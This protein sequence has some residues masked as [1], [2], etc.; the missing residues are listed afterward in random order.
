L[1]LAGLGVPATSDFCG[2]RG[3]FG[4]ENGDGLESGDQRGGEKTF[5]V[6]S[7]FAGPLLAM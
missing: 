5:D 4:E 3:V 6:V 1:I 7:F 2:A